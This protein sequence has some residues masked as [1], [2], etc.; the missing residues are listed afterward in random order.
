MAVAGQ[1]Q[2]RFQRGFVQPHLLLEVKGVAGHEAGRCQPRQR[3]GGRQQHHVKFAAAHA[4]Q[5]GQALRDQVLVRREAVVGQRFP[6]REQRLRAKPAQ[7]TAVRPAAA[8]HRLVRRRRCTTV[9]RRRGA[10]ARDGPIARASAEPMGRGRASRLPRAMVGN[11]MDGADNTNR[12][13]TAAAGRWLDCRQGARSAFAADTA[14]VTATIGEWTPSPP[15]QRRRDSARY[16]A[17]VPC[18]GVE[19]RRAGPA[20]AVRADR[21]SRAM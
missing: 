12:P 1:R 19:A 9:A 13:A 15:R 14:Y 2:L 20:E 10:P 16:F 4:P 3:R 8:A 18:A 17:L 21:R 6:I 11:C 5:R 7:R